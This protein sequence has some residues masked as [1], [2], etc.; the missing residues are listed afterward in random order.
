MAVSALAKFALFLVVASAAGAP[1]PQHP[2]QAASLPQAAAKAANQTAA[3]PPA[4]A[5]APSA[6]LSQTG[7]K[8]QIVHQAA[9]PAGAKIAPFG[10]EDTAR[11][12]QDHAARTQDT[13]V[14]AVENAEVA[15]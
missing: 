15:E 3:P 1:A 5:A 4:K 2:A 12:L 13:L 14:G 6:S 8:E 9:A 7:A 11:E 10:K